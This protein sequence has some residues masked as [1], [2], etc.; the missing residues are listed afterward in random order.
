MQLY[1]QL[2]WQLKWYSNNW[3][4]SD[5]F[6]LKEIEAKYGLT[7]YFEI[8]AKC[9]ENSK[10]LI[11]FYGLTLTAEQNSK[12]RWICISQ[13]DTVERKPFILVENYNL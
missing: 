12:M 10:M 13:R 6:L 11:Q 8:I 9:Y 5:Q 7:S 2:E 1:L 4:L 3:M